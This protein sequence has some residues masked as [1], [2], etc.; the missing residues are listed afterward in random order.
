[1]VNPTVSK[2]LEP[3]VSSIRPIYAY[4]ATT[5]RSL[6]KEQLPALRSANRNWTTLSGKG[7]GSGR[8]GWLDGEELTIILLCLFLRP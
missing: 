6:E 1:M 7:G 2:Y 5:L 3:P 4:S 8:A